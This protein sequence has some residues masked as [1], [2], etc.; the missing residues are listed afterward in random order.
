[1]ANAYPVPTFH[2]LHI[3][4]QTLVVQRDRSMLGTR[5]GSEKL[6]EPAPKREKF[7]KGRGKYS[8][9]PRKAK[10]RALLP[11]V[12]FWGFLR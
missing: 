5:R 9:Y 10:R 1:M 7:H 12:L 8:P 3:P 6:W 11:A 2:K 4:G